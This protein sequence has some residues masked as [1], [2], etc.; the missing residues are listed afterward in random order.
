MGR[1]KLEGLGMSMNF[2]NMVFLSEK[3]A[4]RKFSGGT[5]MSDLKMARRSD[6]V[7]L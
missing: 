5:Q 4:L 2:D 7:M 6:L 1:N 3:K